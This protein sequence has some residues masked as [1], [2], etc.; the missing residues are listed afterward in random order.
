MSLDIEM[1][2][3]RVVTKLRDCGVEQ[4]DVR[5]LNVLWNPEIRKVIL[6][7]FKRSEILKQ[8]LMR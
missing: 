4:G 8:I 1:E 6:V 7:D 5:P 2:T 3:N